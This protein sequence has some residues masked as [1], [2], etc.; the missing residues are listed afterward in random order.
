MHLGV[1]RAG[2]VLR[3]T[4]RRD[5]GGI[6]DRALAQQQ[7]FVLEHGVDG[8]QE[9]DGECVLLQPVTEAQDR[10][11]IRERVLARIAGMSCSASSI[12]GSER[13]NHCC[14]KWMRSMVSA[15][16]GTRP[17]RGPS[18]GCAGDTSATNCAQGITTSISFKKRCRLVTSSG[19]RI[20]FR[21]GRFASSTAQTYISAAR[22][23]VLD[24]VGAVQRS[25]SSM[26]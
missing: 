3:G 17:P 15:G 10:T 2:L 4:G 9:L 13:A 25:P 24:S 21:R 23:I 16:N 12:A 26:L 11:L 6:H 14:M 7:P 20:R 19:V 8:C 18:L 5:Q 22:R 1:A